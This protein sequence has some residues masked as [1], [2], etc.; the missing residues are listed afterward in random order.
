MSAQTQTAETAYSSID[1]EEVEQFSRIA[2]EWWDPNGKFKPLHQ[3]NPLRIG[4]IRDHVCKALGRDPKSMRA[5]EGLEMLDIGCGGGLICEPMAR[6][7]ASVTGIDASEKNIKTASI[8]AEQ[9]GLSIDYRATTAEDLGAEK[10]QYDVVL[11]LEII[12]HVVD[13]QAFIDACAAL[14]KPGGI[15]IMTTINRTAKSFAFAIVGAEYVLRLLP[16][17]THQWEKFVKPS[18]MAQGLQRNAFA[19]LNQSGMVMNPLR[20]EWK[21]SEK[22]LSVNYLMVGEKRK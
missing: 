22:D 2:E 19:I 4:Y 9:S 21:L 6:M 7:G 3:I 17:G 8:H 11:A 10:K 14:V 16:R 1:P 18:E 15:L 20:W 13:P 12:E 5:F